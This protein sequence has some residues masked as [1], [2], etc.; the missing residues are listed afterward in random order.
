MKSWATIEKLN[1]KV[2]YDKASDRYVGGFGNNYLK[3]WAESIEDL[4]KVKKIKVRFLGYK[5]C[6][7]RLIAD[8]L[9]DF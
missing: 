3:C 8:S 2:V 9:L 1:T 6:L 5:Y 7:P 4:K